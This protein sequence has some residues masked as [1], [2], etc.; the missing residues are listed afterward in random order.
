DVVGKVIHGTGRV[1][2]SVTEASSMMGSMELVYLSAGSIQGVASSTPFSGRFSPGARAGL[3][4][5]W[6][7]DDQQRICTSMRMGGV[8]LAPR[9]QF[10]YAYDKRYFISDSDSDRSARVSTFALQP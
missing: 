10:W 7:I 9:C 4:G 5:S 2:A 1:A 8:V 6:A 3:Q